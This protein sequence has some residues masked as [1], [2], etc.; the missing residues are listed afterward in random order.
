[1]QLRRHER[2]DTL[3]EVLFAIAVFSMVV[4]GSVAIM[5]VG[6]AAAQRTLGLTV[7]RQV[8]DSQAQ[9]LRLAHDSYLAQYS[10]S[11]P[12]SS[13]TG[14]AAL[15]ATIEQKA[16]ETPGSSF[17]GSTQCPNSGTGAPTLRANSFVMYSPATGS[18]LVLDWLGSNQTPDTY[19]T[20]TV[21]STGRPVVQGIWVEAV[22]QPVELTANP[23]VPVGYIDFHINACW[24]G[25]G[26]NVP[27]TIG[28][29]VRLYDPAE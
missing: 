5:N 13:Y 4:V 19:P 2:G 18:N 21:D 29:I 8:I 16:A 23:K 27:V 15:Y 14:A 9:M 3:I 28:T 26:S 7:M 1:M 17:I 22:K 24:P 11:A 6:T 20:V 25:P 12:T 10:P